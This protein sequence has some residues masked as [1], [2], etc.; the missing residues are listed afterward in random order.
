MTADPTGAPGSVGL[1]TLLD[2]VLGVIQP[3]LRA[4]TLPVLSVGCFPPCCGKPSS[5]SSQRVVRKASTWQCSGNSLLL[6]FPLL[7]LV[8]LAHQGMFMEQ[9]GESYQKFAIRPGS[10]GHPCRVQHGLGGSCCL[11]A[12]QCLLD[13]AH[14]LKL[15]PWILPL[16]T[17][18]NLALL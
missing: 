5:G 16:H 7:V 12:F 4:I 17:V 9:G 11:L 6:L 3:L 18:F 2:S 15:N 14:L 10:L 13:K 1:G 8:F